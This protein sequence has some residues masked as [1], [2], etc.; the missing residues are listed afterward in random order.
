MQCLL[1]VQVVGRGSGL[2]PNETQTSVFKKKKVSL[3]GTVTVWGFLRQ[4]I[5]D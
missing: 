1:Y 4:S 5:G 3:L 2:F